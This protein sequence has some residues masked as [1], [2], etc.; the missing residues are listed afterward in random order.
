PEGYGDEYAV[1]PFDLQEG[2]FHFSRMF[3]AMCFRILSQE[4][5]P[6][7]QGIRQLRVDADLSQRCLPCARAHDGKWR[8]HAR[9]IWAHKNAT[10]RQINFGKDRA[11]HVA[12]VDI[13][14]MRHPAAQG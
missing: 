6:S 10:P 14:R 8:S 3:G 7:L 4:W 12:R 1:R 5:K 13:T 11:G 9:V 2:Q